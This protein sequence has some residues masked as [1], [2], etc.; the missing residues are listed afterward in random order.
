MTGMI[1]KKKIWKVCLWN[2]LALNVQ[3]GKWHMG[4]LKIYCKSAL[5]TLEL[6]MG[7]LV[8]KTVWGIARKW[9]SP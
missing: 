6:K 9:V 7:S 3:N 1:K 4:N 2:S 8:E 5:Q